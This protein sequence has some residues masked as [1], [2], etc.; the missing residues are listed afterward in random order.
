MRQ[1]F[2]IFGGNQNQC[3]YTGEWFCNEH[4]AEERIS[5]P[6][7]ALK[8]FDLKGYAVSIKAYCEIKSYY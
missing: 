6:W 5:I 8:N 1:G 4:M 3:M 7:K 2:Y